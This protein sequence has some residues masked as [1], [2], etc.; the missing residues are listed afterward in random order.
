MSLPE[1]PNP[2]NILTRE[3]AINAI[4][5]SIAMEETALSHIINAEG[6]K[7][8]YAIQCIDCN[9]CCVA[10]QMILDVN[11]SVTSLIEQINDMQLLMKNKMRLAVNFLPQELNEGPCVPCFPTR[12]E[13]PCTNPCQNPCSGACQC[14]NPC[15][16]ACQNPCAS[17]CH[18]QSQTLCPSIC[19]CQRQPPPQTS[20]TSACQRQCQNPCQNLCSSICECQCQNPSHNLRSSICQCQNPCRSQCQNKCQSPCRNQCRSIWPSIG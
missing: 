10:M 19:H 6:E 13:K 12:P 1:F 2:E 17:T 3:E 7:I 16:N 5:T 15:K 18:C 9:Q 14:Q 11:R 8:Q 20:C 4:L